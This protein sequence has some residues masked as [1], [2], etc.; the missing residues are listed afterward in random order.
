MREKKGRR[1]IALCMVLTM[2]LSLLTISPELSITAQAATKKYVKSLNV[3]NSVKVAV[4]SKVVVS[5][6]VQATKKT[7][8]KLKVKVK[9]KKVARAT[10]SVKT[11]KIT[12]Y[13]KKVGNTTVTVSTVAK[14]KKGKV[15]SKKIKVAV[16]QKKQNTSETT[17][18]TTEATTE[19]S[20]QESTEKKETITTV[21][22]NKDNPNVVTRMEWIESLLDTVQITESTQIQNDSLQNIF[23][24]VTDDSELYIL[25]LA[26]KNNILEYSEGDSFYPDQATTREFAAVTAIKACGFQ[27]TDNENDLECS[28]VADLCYA[29]YDN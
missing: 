26:V 3:K 25:D 12:I 22:E 7:N 15:I 5:P 24:D 11:K 27:I 8:T 16:T 20:T 2:L 4:G 28:D 29:K 17:E 14:N 23:S 13:G 1:W 18:V 9:N 21:D 6:K 10:Y 19:G